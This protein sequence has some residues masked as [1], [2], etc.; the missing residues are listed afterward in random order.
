MREFD[1]ISQIYPPPKEPR[2]VGRNIRTIQ[3]RLVASERTREFYDGDRN[4]GYGGYKYDGRWQPIAKKLYETYQLNPQSKVLQLASEKGFLLNDF[5]TAY[6][7][8]SLTGLE[9]SDYAISETMPLVKPFVSKG[10]YTELPYADHVFDLVIAIGVVY[11]FNLTDA[12]KCLREIQRV[13]KGKSF[14]NLSTYETEE[15]YWLFK[16]WSLLGAT[17]LK[18]QEWREVMAY[19][20]YTGDYAFTGAKKLNLIRK[21]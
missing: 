19:A 7:E 6:P 4:N 2:A 11:I 10:I 3:N 1:P 13:S 18:P 5:K 12:V 9:M 21:D 15:E 14:I 20:G 17:M 16:D 8:M